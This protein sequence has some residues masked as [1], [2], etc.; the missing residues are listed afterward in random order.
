M[1]SIGVVR[2]MHGAR[3]IGAA[4]VTLNYCFAPEEAAFVVHNCDAAVVSAD[5]EFRD[6]AAAIRPDA[7]RCA[8]GSSTTASRARGCWARR[9]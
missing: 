6:L 2:M 3:K 4:A 5:A 8:T 9:R 7:R 1:N